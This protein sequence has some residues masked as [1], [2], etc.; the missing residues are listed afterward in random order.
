MLI[1]SLHKSKLSVGGSTFGIS[2]KDVVPP[3]IAD[4]D[5]V[6]MLPLSVNPG[7]LK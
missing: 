6:L 1:L 2:I 7:S 3:A 5:S 4:N